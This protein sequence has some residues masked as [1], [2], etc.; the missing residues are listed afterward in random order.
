MERTLCLLIN[1]RVFSSQLWPNTNSLVYLIKPDEYLTKLLIYLSFYAEGTC[2]N[3]H[4]TTTIHSYLFIRLFLVLGT[5][6][7]IYE[8]LTSLEVINDSKAT[9]QFV[10][11]YHNYSFIFLMNMVDM[12]CGN[13][14]HI[15]PPFWQFYSILI[16]DM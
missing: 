14:I 3:R 10:T 11:I 7:V 1:Y 12:M 15:I 16:S 8:I 6:V 4:D 2:F 9:I 13:I 5:I